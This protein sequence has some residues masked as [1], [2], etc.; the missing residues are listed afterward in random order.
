M[1]PTLFAVKKMY[2]TY[3]FKSTAM[4]SYFKCYILT[5]ECSKTTT[6][7]VKSA[8]LALKKYFH[9]KT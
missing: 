2:N 6:Y 4:C 5:V 9:K 3:A 8:L 1:V 7:A